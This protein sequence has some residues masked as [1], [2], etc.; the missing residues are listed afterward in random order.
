LV[1]GNTKNKQ[2]GKLREALTGNLKAHHQQTLKWEK[3][4]YDLLQAQIDECLFCMEKICQEHYPK[5]SIRDN[6]ID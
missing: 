1:Y 5:M 4:S 6:G 2:S 3:D